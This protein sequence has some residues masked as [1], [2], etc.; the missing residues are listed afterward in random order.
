MNNLLD[1][2]KR[3]DEVNGKLRENMRERNHLFS[4][5]K[6]L[7][8]KAREES[9]KCRDRCLELAPHDTLQDGTAV[10]RAVDDAIENYDGVD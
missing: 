1:I 7:N 3:I 5:L 10:Y 4:E 8:Q 2:G 9:T 6:E